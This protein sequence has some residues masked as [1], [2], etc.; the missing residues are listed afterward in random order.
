MIVLYTQHVYR[1]KINNSIT[2]LNK[3]GLKPLLHQKL[4]YIDYKFKV[5]ENLLRR[6]EEPSMNNGVEMRFPYLS[7]KLIDF[8]I[9]CPLEILLVME[10]Q[11]FI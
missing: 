11:K 4:I 5:S 8:I 10:L 3:L 2:D 7:S 9:K 6:A 1:M